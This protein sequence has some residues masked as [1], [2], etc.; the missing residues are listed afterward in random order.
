[1]GE[2]KKY[3]EA[4]MEAIGRAGIVK[5]TLRNKL[6]LARCFDLLGQLKQCADMLESETPPD[7]DIPVGVGLLAYRS[8]IKLFQGRLRGA[9]EDAEAAV[10]QASRGT[11]RDL[12]DALLHR[13]EYAL[14]A[15]DTVTAATDLDGAKR[16]SGTA[17][18]VH[19]PF[20]D[21]LLGISQT[22]LLILQGDL[23]NGALQAEAACLVFERGSHEIWAGA[24]RL[25]TARCL[26]H[27]DVSSADR[28][29][30]RVE[31]FA[32]ERSILSMQ[33]NALTLRGLLAH[34]MNRLDEAGQ[35]ASRIGSPWIL[36]SIAHVRF[37]VFGGRRD[38]KAAA[39]AH[40][41]FLSHMSIVSSELDQAARARVLGAAEKNL[42]PFLI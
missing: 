33:A 29:A 21:A 37:R 27:S 34:D 2:A 22:E 39:V 25:L 9:R 16:A 6:R 30:A 26:A 41:A 20:E 24:A 5:G 17:R 1:V 15:A 10:R 14:A 19:R 36:A 4:E 40:K 42:H 28:L 32:R 7:G 3:S 38:E 13:A 12:A 23:S 8:Q 18:G 11:G 31:A 35:L